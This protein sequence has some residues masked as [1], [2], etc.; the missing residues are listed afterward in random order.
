MSEHEVYLE[1]DIPQYDTTKMHDTLKKVVKHYGNDSQM[2]KTIEELSELQKELCKYIN[3][4]QNTKNIYEEM[5]DVSIMIYQLSLIMGITQ[6]TI[7]P[8]I[9]YKLR[10]LEQRIDNETKNE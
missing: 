9:D 8:Y 10:R 3:G 7:Q 4:E 2:I 1:G 6:H 5:A